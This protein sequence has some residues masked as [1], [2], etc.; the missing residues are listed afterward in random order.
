[1][2]IKYCEQARNKHLSDFEELRQKVIDTDLPQNQVPKTA[3]K[4][5]KK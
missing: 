5:R 4:R 1:M 3:L 2:N